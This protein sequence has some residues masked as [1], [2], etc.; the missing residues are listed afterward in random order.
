[1]LKRRLS[2]NLKI[3]SIFIT[4]EKQLSAFKRDDQSSMLMN[5]SLSKPRIKTPRPRRYVFTLVN[6]EMTID[7]LHAELECRGILSSIREYAFNLADGEIF[8]RFANRS[9]IGSIAK[10]VDLLVRSRPFPDLYSNTPMS[11]F[12][13]KFGYSYVLGDATTTTSGSSP[14]SESSRD[15]KKE[16]R[17]KICKG[18]KVEDL[19]KEAQDCQ[20]YDMLI[21]IFDYEQELIK[22][23]K[24]I[25]GT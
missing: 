14:T 1:M 10:H 25:A 21:A 12:A 16:A 7:I 15:L 24:W 20:D 9:D 8:V 3:K 22:L 18:I 19:K 23:E 13:R 2:K 5:A 11:L 6:P 17:L 4:V